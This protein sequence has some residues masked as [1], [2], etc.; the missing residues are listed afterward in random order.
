MSPSWT[1]YSWM[2]IIWILYNPFFT[3]YIYQLL[4]FSRT[5]SFFFLVCIEALS[6]FGRYLMSIFCWWWNSRRGV[7]IQ[8]NLWHY[9]KIMFNAEIYQK[10]QLCFNMAVW[11]CYEQLP[12]LTLGRTKTIK[13]TIPGIWMR[14]I[15]KTASG[16]FIM[17]HNTILRP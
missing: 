1:K 2:L 6:W 10:Q 15:G 11:I 14:Y 3:C 16:W 4:F 7:I 9:L 8:K 5:I 12:R 17:S 13:Y